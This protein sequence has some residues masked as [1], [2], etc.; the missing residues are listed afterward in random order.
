[1]DL[2]LGLLA[3]RTMRKK[4]KEFCCLSSPV[5]YDLLWQPGHSNQSL[6]SWPQ[7]GN[8]EGYRRKF[9]PSVWGFLPEY[10]FLSILQPNLMEQCE[11]YQ[12]C[13]THTHNI[14][15]YGLSGSTSAFQI[16]NRFWEKFHSKGKYSWPLSNMEINLHII[17]WQ[18]FVSAVLPYLQ[19][20]PT[21]DCVEL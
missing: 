1:M 3:S 6:L 12:K 7:S 8:Q 15:Y 18:P 5:C 14:A 2:H 13:A 21:T 19:I 11:N 10:C 4:K 9:I 17:Y 16:T 20:Q